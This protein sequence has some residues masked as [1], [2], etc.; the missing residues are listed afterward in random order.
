MYSRVGK[1]HFVRLQAPETICGIQQATSFGA[2]CFQQ[3]VSLTNIP[4]GIKLNFPVVPIMTMSEDCKSCLTPYIHWMTAG[5]GL[6]V[7][8]VKPSNIAKGQKLPVLF[9]SSAITVSK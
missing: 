8:V 7:N 9:V 1:L 4:S 3:N 5:V 2:A 6:F